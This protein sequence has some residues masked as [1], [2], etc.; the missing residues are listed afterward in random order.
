MKSFIFG[1]AVLLLCSAVEAQ[2]VI[3]PR[4]LVFTASP[5]HATVLSDGSPSVAAYEVRWFAAGAVAPLSSATLGKPAPNASGV[6]TVDLSMLIAGI[7]IGVGYTAKVVA[8]GQAG[9]G[10]SAPSNPFDVASPPR[11]ATNVALSR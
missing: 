8:V 4:R 5:D 3:N 2:T 10:I 1:L 9:E 11:P 7:P 6:I